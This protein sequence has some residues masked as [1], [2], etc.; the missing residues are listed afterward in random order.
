MTPE[1]KFL[2]L[3][4]YLNIF[5]KSFFFAIPTSQLMQTKT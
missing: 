5:M 4:L 2:G 3:F 1:N